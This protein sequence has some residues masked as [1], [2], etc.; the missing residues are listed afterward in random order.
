[1]SLY[2]KVTVPPLQLESR[3]NRLRKL[4]AGKG[5]GTVASSSL[6]QR[7]DGTLSAE[8]GLM[9]RTTDIFG[10]LRTRAVVASK[11]SATE[12]FDK[13]GNSSTTN[14]SQGTTLCLESLT[15]FM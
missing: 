9:D 7:Q 4:A 14:Q 15:P 5:G 2:L 10:T 12:V 1:M 8:M 13:L 6:Q 3:L 11:L